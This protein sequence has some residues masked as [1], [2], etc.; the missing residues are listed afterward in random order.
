MGSYR[1]LLHD[2]FN[3]NVIFTTLSKCKD[4]IFYNGL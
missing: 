3:S 1:G 2:F 4:F